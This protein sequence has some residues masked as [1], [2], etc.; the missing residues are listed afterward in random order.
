MDGRAE[1]APQLRQGGSG[2]ITVAEADSNHRPHNTGHNTHTNSINTTADNEALD[3]NINSSGGDMSVENVTNPDQG[4][5]WMPHVRLSEDELNKQFPKLECPDEQLYE[6]I[7]DDNG[8]VV[9]QHG[10]KLADH[11]SEGMVR[12]G[13]TRTDHLNDEPQV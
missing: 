10:L 4:I 2:K 5:P 6:D 13:R 7:I 11:I 9:F 8:D 3:T 12:S 1:S